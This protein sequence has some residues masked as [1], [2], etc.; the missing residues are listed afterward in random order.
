MR[1]QAT[2]ST[3]REQFSLHAEGYA[4][5]NIIQNKVVSALLASVV[6]KPRSVLDLG[7]GGGAVYKAI[8]WPVENFTAVDF[9]P[10]MLE[11]HPGGPGIEIILGDFDDPGLFRRLQGRRF[12][13]VISA[14]ALQWAVNL[15]LVFRNVGKIGASLSF[16]I[17]TSGTFSKIYETAA[18]PPLL[19]SADEVVSCAEK[20]FSARYELKTYTL[21][22][23]SLREMFRYIKKSGVSGGRKILD[24]RQAKRLISDYPLRHLEF[25]VLLMHT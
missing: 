2:Q 1:M 8:T 12:D 3:V 17:F 18:L 19:R 4:R 16:A 21:N 7:C 6:D 15:D 25:E 14:S 22:F 13:R 9:A 5:Y 20:Y 23:A 11:L 10:G 24:Y